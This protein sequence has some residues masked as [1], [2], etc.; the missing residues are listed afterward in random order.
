MNLKQTCEVLNDKIHKCINKL[1]QQDSASP[2]N[3]ED[4]N[5]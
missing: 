3:V 1:V 2:H 4:I 5:N